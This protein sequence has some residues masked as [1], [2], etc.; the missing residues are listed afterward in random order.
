LRI[1]ESFVHESI[2]SKFIG[3]AEG[4]DQVGDFRP[5]FLPLKVGHVSPDIIRSSS[6]MKMILMHMDYR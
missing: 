6:M 2:G 1:G 3:K 5:S 4:F